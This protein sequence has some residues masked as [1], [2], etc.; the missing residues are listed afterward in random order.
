VLA[1]LSGGGDSL[2]LLLLLRR[3]LDRHA[4]GLHL[5]AVT[6]DHGLRPDSAA[7]AAAAGELAVQLGVSH[8]ILRW[9]GEKPRTGLMA[10]AREARFRLLAKAAQAQGARLVFTGHTADDQAETVAMR[11]A[12]ADQGPGLSGMAPLALLDARI[13]IAR[14]LLGV[15]GAALRALLARE[16]LSWIE[17]P[18]NENPFFERV[19]VRQGL[20][21]VEKLAWLDRAEQAGFSRAALG[22]Q[23]AGLIAAHA[24]RP[25]P[26]LVRL[27][28]G[29]LDAQEGEAALWAFRLLLACVGG[30]THP[31]DALRAE[32]LLARLRAGPARA[33]LGGAVVGSAR[34]AVLLRPERRGGREAARAMSPAPFAHLLPLFDVALARALGKLFGAPNIPAPPCR[35]PLWPD[36]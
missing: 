32:K 22:R 18:S 31:P 8:Q 35:G 6:V 29:F 34:D 11:A 17:D 3:F 16:N 20:S 5:L 2:A 13:W 26:G 24:A 19:R 21:E 27:D 30:R 28:P 25:E 7:E 12:R 14:P 33:S 4:P 23:A 1:A 36:A 15:R 10:G 9:E